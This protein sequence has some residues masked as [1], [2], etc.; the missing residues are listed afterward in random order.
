MM[1]LR[2]RWARVKARLE[3]QRPVPAL[4]RDAVALWQ[5][6]YG[7]D[8]D[9]WQAEVLLGEAP[10]LCLNCSRQVGKSSVA[11]VLGLHTALTARALILLVSRSLRQSQELGKKLFDA[12]RA[13]GKPVSADAESRLSLELTNGS[14]VVC[15]PGNEATIRGFSGPAL[16]IIDEASRVPDATYHALRP[17]LAVSQGR[18]LCLSTPFGQRGWW[19]E[20]WTKGQDWRKVLITAEQCS[21]I[22]AAFLAEERRTL[23]PWVY[24]QE[25]CGVFAANQ[26]GAFNREDIVAAIAETVR[27]LF[28]RAEELLSG[29]E[30]TPRTVD[31]A[32]LEGLRVEALK[33]LWG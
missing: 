26:Q 24:E 21:R 2:R 14:R 31:P 7:T 18:L 20:A 28:G 10:R 32:W 11:A 30:E 9:P 27:P 22:S 15:L 6:L 3:A 19:Y 13:L 8:P 29:V 25:Y 33:P 23:P 5:R 1:A 4:A 16:V 12:Y 17:M